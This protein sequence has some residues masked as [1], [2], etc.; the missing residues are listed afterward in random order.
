MTPRNIVVDIPTPRGDIRSAPL[1]PSF[2]YTRSTGPVLGRFFTGLREGRV[3][4]VRDSRGV[5]HVPPVEFDPHTRAAISDDAFVEVASTGEVTTWTWVNEPAAIH[6]LDRPFAWA[7]V[8]LDGADTAMLLPVDCGAVEDISTG[9]RVRL[10][11]ADERRGS[12]HDIECAVPAVDAA[13]HADDAAADRTPSSDPEPITGIVTPIALSVTHN[14]SPSESRFLDAIVEGRV[15][16][17]RRSNGEEVYV[18]PRD[19]IPSDGVAAGEYVEVSDHGTVTTFGIV[20]VPF[21]GQEVTPPYVT[22]YILLDGS[23]LPIQHLV[24]GCDA[25]EVHMGMRVRAVWK[26]EEDRPA[27]MLA[28]SHFE[29][30]G[31]PDAAPDTYERHL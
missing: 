9:M 20:N 17:R 16:G 4:G 26:P 3:Y 14:A 29:P 1:T 2:D 7:L 10:R 27:S 21:L 31:E 22:A 19:Y 13:E 12:V 6:R 18:P 25:A 24:L 8:L 15:L 5:V 11:W 30:S 28:I 23:D